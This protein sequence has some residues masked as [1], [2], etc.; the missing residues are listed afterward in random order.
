M[1][2][3]LQRV[4]G[5][6]G[7]AG[8]AAAGSRS[9]PAGRADGEGPEAGAFRLNE[10]EAYG[11]LAACG[12]AHGPVAVLPKG[13]STLAR[14]EWAR[15]AAALVDAE[16]RLLLKV[17]GRELLHKSDVGGIRSLVLA[18]RQDVGRLLAEADALL[19]GLPP[20]AAAAAEGVLACGF[21]PHR[22]NLPGQELLLSLRQDPAFGP[23][24]VVGIGGLL[25]EWYGRGSGGRS[26]LIF[27][28]GGLT[29]EAVAEAVAAHPLLSIAC[30]RSR[31]H[32]RAPLAAREIGAAAAALAG[33]GLACGAA[34]EAPFTLEELEVNPAV[35][36]DGRLVAIDGVGLASRRKQEPADRPLAKIEPLLAPRSAVVLGVSARGANPGRIILENLKGSASVEP[37]RLRVVHP[38]EEAIAGVPCVAGLGDLPGKVDL[39]VVAVPAEGAR[40]AIAE[41]V[42]RD[43]A[44]AII[45]IPGGFAEAGRGDLAGQI[46]ATLRR[47]HRSP[48]GGPVMVGGNC[49]GI[50][51]RDRYNTFF[52]PHYKLPFNP[53]HGANLAIVSQSGAY[54]VTFASNYDGIVFPAASISIGNQMDLT[55]ADFLSHL[56]QRPGIDVVACY[57]EGFRPGDGERFLRFVREARRDGKRVLV[58]KAGKTELGARAAASHTASLAGDYDVARA[59]LEAAGADVAETLDAFED[60]IKTFTLLAGKRPRGRRVAVISNAGF[61]CSTATDRLSGLELASLDEAARQDL[62]EALPPFAHRDNPVD[63]TPVADTEAYVRSVSALLRS[64]AVDLAIV[65]SVPVTPALD[66]LEPDPRGRHREDL[67]SPESQPSRLIELLA[68]SPKPAVMVIDSGPLYDPMARMMERA[69]IPVFRKID[70]AAAALGALCR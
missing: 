61:E 34:G 33:L 10:H 39:A 69:G 59:C 45:L 27:P 3:D 68:G 38:R 64:P 46:V 25:T 50:V 55:V 60:Q 47:G 26:R 16:G 56:R 30:T 67:R 22:P 53:G 5:V 29:A 4:L 42:D 44:E 8:R 17:L 49:L 65:S 18:D 62:V 54:L 21:V 66:N 13:T 37:G 41:L 58:F 51:S 15:E 12:L 23:V 14:S 19:A 11:I 57:V 52:L 48:G 20:A 63:A 40:D 70:R 43:L 7:E 9:A 31:L 1:A 28:A 35:A 24:V 32:A 36:A 2:M 6:L